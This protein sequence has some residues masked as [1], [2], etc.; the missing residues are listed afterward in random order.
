VSRIAGVFRLAAEGDDVAG[1]IAPVSARSGNLVIAADV[2]IDARADLIRALKSEGAE[3]ADDDADAAL[4]IA[5]YRAWGDA[6]V[7]HIIGDFAFVIWDASRRRV[8]AARDHFGVKPFYFAKTQD[9]LVVANTIDAVL[10]HPVVSRELDDEAVVNF[11]LF[12][13]N[14]NEASTTYAQIRC[15]PAAHSLVFENGVARV[16]RYWSLP[17]EGELRYAKPR[18]YAE[19]FT[20]L[21]DAAVSDRIP[22]EGFAVLMSGGT[23]STAIAAT[24]CKLLSAR[25]ASAEMPHA[26]CG[27]FSELFAD[28]EPSYAALAAD[29]LGM[30]FTFVPLDKH[31]AYDNCGSR[32]RTPEPYDNP[33]FAAEHDLHSAA[34]AHARVAL[35]GYGGDAVLRETRSHLVRLIAAGRPFT[36]SREA[37]EY[38]QLYGR[39]PRPG[40]RTWLKERRG[41]LLGRGEVPVWLVPGMAHKLD[42]EARIASIERRP[43]NVHPLRPEAFAHLSGAFWPRCFEQCDTAMTRVPLEMRHP[44]MDVRL[45]DF[46]LSVPPAQWYNDKG[47]LRLAMQHLLPQ[48]IVRRPKAPLAGDPLRAVFERDGAGWLGERR[49]TS[50]VSAYVRAEELPIQVGGRAQR[51]LSQHLDGDLRPLTLSLWLT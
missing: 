40:V 16:T 24:A 33:L 31:R 49:V 3:V 14:T 21:L 12:G 2:R 36:A 27:G 13:Y 47:V 51:A 41:E 6:C 19:H 45:V 5:A 43:R 48:A 4:L 35:T 20:T 9:D 8:F 39:L 11:L 34:A 22:L 18:D 28:A 17:L 25:G 50:N 29:A 10:A 46:A 30:P 32:A 7:T 15:L 38:V 23:D 1:R 42:A 26:I 37:L 44:F